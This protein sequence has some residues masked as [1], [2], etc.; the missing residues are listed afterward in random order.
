MLGAEC[1]SLN[2]QHSVNSPLNPNPPLATVSN[3]FRPP[4]AALN[5]FDHYPL[6]RSA[7]HTLRSFGGCAHHLTRF[8]YLADDIQIRPAPR[9]RPHIRLWNIEIRN[10]L[11]YGIEG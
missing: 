9:L 3:Q 6:L 1:Y 8:A 2:L 7:P 4:P 5:P 11:T 10:G